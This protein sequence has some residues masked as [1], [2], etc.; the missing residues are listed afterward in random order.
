MI[1]SHTPMNGVCYCLCYSSPEYL[2]DQWALHAAG[3]P[4]NSFTAIKGKLLSGLRRLDCDCMQLTPAEPPGLQRNN[5]GR[6]TLCILIILFQLRWGRRKNQLPADFKVWEQKVQPNELAARPL[7]VA[8]LSTFKLGAEPWASQLDLRTCTNT[9]LPSLNRA[10]RFLP[11]LFQ[12]FLGFTSGSMRLFPPTHLCQVQCLGFTTKSDFPD[13]KSWCWDLALGLRDLRFP[14][15]QQVLLSLV[16]YFP[17]HCNSLPPGP[18]PE[19][20]G[21]GQR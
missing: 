12:G 13:A 4:T 10:C 14:G 3:W 15:I 11:T 6:H 7:S 20:M 2:N 1:Q 5:S 8:F 18:T 21:W 19:Q 9:S 16:N 17:V